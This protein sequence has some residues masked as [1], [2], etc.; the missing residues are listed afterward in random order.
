MKFTV[1]RDVLAEAV[2]WT[3][4]SLPLRPTSPV[5][6]GLLITASAGEVSIAS[7]DHETS[8]RQVIAA[9]VQAE[10]VFPVRF[11]LRFA[12]LCRTP[13]LSSPPMSP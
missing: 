4:R 9:D 12:V 2:G 8:A 13:R 10:G 7:F 5:L 6:N 3:A 11:W 1:E